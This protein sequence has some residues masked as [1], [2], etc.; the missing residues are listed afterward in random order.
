VRCSPRTGRA[1]RP[2]LTFCKVFL[3]VKLVAT[4]S[5]DVAERYT[6]HKIRSVPGF[7]RATARFGYRDVIDLQGIVRYA[8]A[9]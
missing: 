6:V 5:L 9:L 8:L 4:P 7:Y 1:G 2:S 3:A